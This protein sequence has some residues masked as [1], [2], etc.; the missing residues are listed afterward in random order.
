MGLDSLDLKFRI[1]QTFKIS[2][3][4][5]EMMGLVRENDLRVGDLYDYLLKKL[6]L[7]DRA[8]YDLHLNYELWR[9]IQRTLQFITSRPVEEITLG[10]RLDRLFPPKTR[11]VAWGALQETSPHRLPDLEYPAIVRLV[12]WL[13]ALAV[14]IFELLP[15]WRAWAN[16][17]WPVLGIVAVW[18]LLETYFKLL[19]V[20]APLRTTLPRGMKTVKDLCRIVLAGNYMQICQQA[21]VPIDERCIDVWHKLQGILQDVLAVEPTQITFQSRLIRDLGMD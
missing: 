3:S 12:G 10:K 14:A 7:Q 6:A 20:F 21:E 2:F 9:E 15:A 11:R 18:M 1:E 17:L 19:Q 4:F 16:W 13:L 8:R 5:D